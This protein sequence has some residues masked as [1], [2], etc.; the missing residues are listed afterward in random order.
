MLSSSSGASSA[1]HALPSM[2]A[3][4]KVFT[5]LVDETQEQATARAPTSSMHL[6]RM[7]DS[8]P[9]DSS[10]SC[11]F[12]WQNLLFEFRRL[13]SLKRL[14]QADACTCGQPSPG[15]DIVWSQ[16]KG[17]GSIIRSSSAHE[18]RQPLSRD[19]VANA[20]PAAAHNIVVNVVNVRRGLKR[21]T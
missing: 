8:E 1:L 21:I 16:T 20:E 2:L 4:R 14:G 19:C 9:H 15:L 11:F 12:S 13:A 3:K 17:S 18:R 10:H 7:L 5:E 6:K